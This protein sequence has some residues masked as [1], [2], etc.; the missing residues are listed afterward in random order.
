[1][2]GKGMVQDFS[3]PDTSPS[4]LLDA[5]RLQRPKKA[6]LVADEIKRWIVARHLKPG[7]RLPSEKE[8]IA[9]LR[10]SRGTIREALKI[11]EA[12]GLL[13]ISP[14]ANGGTRV[15]S[16]SYET[17]NAQ[18]K[19]FFYFQELTWSEVYEFRI[20]VE[21]RA[22]ELATPLLSEGDFQ[23]LE[24]TIETCSPAAHGLPHS[25][26]HRIQEN[27]FHRIIAARCP[28]PMLRF[29]TLI[30]LDMLADFVRYRNILQP[31]PDEFASECLNAHGAL[32][33]V[34]RRRDGEAAATMMHDHIKALTA[35]LRIREQ[36]VEPDLLM[37]RRDGI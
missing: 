5:R 17:A 33:N 20:Q 26:E 4:G 35:Y 8:L 22:V 32:L 1:M 25:A 13:T 29:S 21:P 14:G 36:L 24:R 15:A 6:E 10:C 34:L 28:N 12:Q 23:A 11:L 9:A 7:D 3:S 37:R 30:V 18:L 31:N 19:S 16:I 27:R 2:I